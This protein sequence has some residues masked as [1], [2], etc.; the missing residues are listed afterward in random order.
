MSELTFPYRI[1]P[2]LRES[3]SKDFISRYPLLLIQLYKT[4]ERPRS[5]E[6]L[7]DSGADTLLIP[8]RVADSIGLELQDRI[9]SSGV[10][11]RGICRKTKVG[12]IAGRMGAGRLDFGQVE[13][14]VPE[15]EGDIPILIG[16]NPL[17][18]YF[19]VIFKEYRDIPAF[20]L[21]QKRPLPA[22]NGK[23]LSSEA[24]N[25]D[26]RGAPHR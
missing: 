16:R 6:G 7:I 11:E 23:A 12:F 13:A 5:F 1:P 25:Q 19:E 3:Q 10:F 14:T 18:R 20:T 22:S 2:G 26:N 21:I 9:I 24:A 15:S 4:G 8:K 17:F